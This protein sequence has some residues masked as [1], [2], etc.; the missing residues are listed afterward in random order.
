M[1]TSLND[2]LFIAWSSTYLSLKR[3]VSEELQLQGTWE[4]PGGD[5][6]LF[7][8]KK[9]T[10]GWRKNKGLSITGEDA[11]KIM[12]ELCQRVCNYH[13]SNSQA[14]ISSDTQQPNE[15][16]DDGYVDIEKLKLRQQ[17]NSEAI[18]SLSDSILLVTSKFQDFMNKNKTGS[19]F[20]SLAK[21]SCVS[22][23]CA[24]YVDDD[25]VGVDN[26]IAIQESTNPLTNNRGI[27][28]QQRINQSKCKS[29]ICLKN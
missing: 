9:L 3:F 23:E 20:F 10:I 5:R 2:K 4:Q 17:A 22:D 14:S 12:N 28:E 19:P 15:L 27:A 8:S 7:K 1:A 24:N 21:Q 29:M 18:Q 16:S 26:S 13:A 25:C 6:K 11:T